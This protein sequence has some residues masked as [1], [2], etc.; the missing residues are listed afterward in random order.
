ML[1][2]EKRPYL[3]AQNVK[4]Y[5]MLSSVVLLSAVSLAACSSSSMEQ[6]R[7]LYTGEA[8][9]EGNFRAKQQGHGLNGTLAREM[10]NGFAAKHI[11]LMNNMFED[12]ADGGMS[13]MYLLNGSA[14]HIVKVHIYRDAKIRAARM[15]EMYGESKENAVL[16]NALGRTTIRSKGHVSLVYTASGGEKD[17]YEKD[18]LPVFEHVLQQIKEQ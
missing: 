13:Y 4:R 8:T 17:M 16:E 14:R 18:V 3:I 9:T 5:L 10:T 7:K 1:S 6:E 15:E 11:K 12:D 2:K